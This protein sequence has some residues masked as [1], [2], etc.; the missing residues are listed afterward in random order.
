MAIDK[1]IPPDNVLRKQQLEEEALRDVS[2]EGDS[3]SFVDD[4]E[5][6]SIEDESISLNAREYN[7]IPKVKPKFK[8]ELSHDLYKL[9]FKAVDVSI[10]D[11]QIAIKIPRS[12]FDFEPLP[13]SK[14]I[15]RIGDKM[16][17]V[18]YLGGIFNFPSDDSWAITFLILNLNTEES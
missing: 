8:V 2:S 11:F 15:L 10:G 17:P 9:K 14:F 16:Y 7:E 6:V 18:T 13:D 4:S 5:I 1:G 12:D 3:L